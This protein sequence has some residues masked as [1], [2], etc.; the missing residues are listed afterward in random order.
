MQSF[1]YHLNIIELTVPLLLGMSASAIAQNAI[2][3]TKAGSPDPDGSQAK[4]YQMVEAGIVRTLTSPART[5]E[6]AAGKYYETFTTDTPVVLTAAGGSAVIGKLGYQAATT[7]E[8]IILNTHLAGDEV[9]MP[10]WQDYERADDI[11]DFFGGPNP[12][13][14]V[15]GFQ[16]IWDEDLFF[17]GDGANGIRPRSGYPHGDHGDIEGDIL[18]SGL[19]LMS[20]YP[21]VGFAQVEYE[22]EAGTFE[23][24]AAKGWVQA[25]IYKN[26]FAIG[27][28]NTHTQ[29]DYSSSDLEARSAQIAQLRDAIA[30]YRASHPDH[31]VFAMGDFNVYGEQSEYYNVLIPR[32]GAQAGG[33]DSDRNSPGF[34][35]TGAQHT[36][37]CDCN[38][39]ATYFDDEAVSGRLDYIFYLPSHAGSVE[40]IP[41]TVEVLPFIGRTLSEDGLTTNQSSDHWGLYGKY[42]LIRR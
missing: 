13:P 36:T 18:N 42:K 24:N 3:V 23:P 22:E 21:L 19:A 31:V 26:G 29:A 7:L 16:E 5:V 25:T 11:A 10:S 34:D 30:N 27:L 4:P 39:L 37:Y 20:K 2:Y 38:P 12:S 41:T 15:V 28:F 40:V 6:I 8:I 9:F 17:G 32:M 33:R 35:F 14:D 1:R